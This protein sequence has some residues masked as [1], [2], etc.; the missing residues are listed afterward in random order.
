M[1]VVTVT[2]AILARMERVVISNGDG[3]NTVSAADDNTDAVDSYNS[4]MHGNW[5]ASTADSENTRMI[6]K[7]DD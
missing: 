4:D 3:D 1:L 2:A 7:I 6:H 5:T